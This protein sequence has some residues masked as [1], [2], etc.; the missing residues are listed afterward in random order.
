[1]RKLIKIIFPAVFISAAPSFADSETL[2]SKDK[3][4]DEFLELAEPQKNISGAYY[5]LG[6]TMSQISHRVKAI[7]NN[8]DETNFKKSNSQFDI[9]VIGGFGAAF[10]KK[11]YAGIEMELFQ[12]FSGKTK[13]KGE[14]GIAHSSALGLNMD[15]RFG[16]L[17]PEHGYLVYTTVGFARV[18]GKVAFKDTVQR[19]AKDPEGT[20]GSFYPTFGAGV[21]HKINHLWNVRGDF[22]ISITSKDDNKSLRVSRNSNW[23]YEGK[24]SRLAFRISVTR[25]I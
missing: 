1:M 7:K 12:R 17:F 16:Y 14:V 6:V 19:R 5:G 25:S 2:N 11:Y 21:E 15:V 10:Y 20:F 18:I 22:R 4:S 24:P 13:Y 9:S 23:K 8:V 3:T